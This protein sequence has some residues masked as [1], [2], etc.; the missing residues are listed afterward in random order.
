MFQAI[1]GLRNWPHPRTYGPLELPCDHRSVCFCP[2]LGVFIDLDA[3]CRTSELLKIFFKHTVYDIRIKFIREKYQEIL[4]DLSCI[5][6]CCSKLRPLVYLHIF[7]R[8]L[9]P[10]S[11]NIST[12]SFEKSNVA[13]YNHTTTQIWGTSECTQIVSK[14]VDRG[15]A[16][17]LST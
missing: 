17:V 9:V 2:F 13:L 4:S 1:D 12:A 5:T 14:Y 3:F 6:C 11:F 15:E 7:K 8:T 16:Y 10:V